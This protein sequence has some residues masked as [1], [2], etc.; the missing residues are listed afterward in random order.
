MGARFTIRACFILT[1]DGMTVKK[2]RPTGYVFDAVTEKEAEKEVTFFK[3]L[4]LLITCHDNVSV[5]LRHL[6]ALLES[7]PSFAPLLCALCS[8][9][10]FCYICDWLK[11]YSNLG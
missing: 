9:P 6:K 5:P 1:V 4:R 2:T 8:A 11:V 10:K 3:T 7:N